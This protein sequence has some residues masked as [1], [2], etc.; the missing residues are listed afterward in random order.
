MKQIGNN[1][2]NLQQPSAVT[3]DQCHLTV[4]ERI[5][6]DSVFSGSVHG[7]SHLRLGS[8]SKEG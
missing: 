8:L 5:Q 2:E 4:L 7:I 3:S 6:Q 1:D